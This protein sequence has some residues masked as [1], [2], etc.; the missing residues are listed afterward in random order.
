MTLEPDSDIY[1]ECV[2]MN[3][4]LLSGSFS[5]FVKWRSYQELLYKAMVRI[6]IINY[7]QC[8]VVCSVKYPTHSEYFICQLIIT[9]ITQFK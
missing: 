4:F 3:K 2:T 7:V 8:N 6:K 9:I 5:C 1:I